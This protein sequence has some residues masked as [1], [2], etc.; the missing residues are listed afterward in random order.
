MILSKSASALAS[1]ILTSSTPG[2]ASARTFIALKPGETPAQAQQRALRIKSQLREQ[3]AIKL[4]T[5]GA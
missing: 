1:A 2:D 3:Q 5:Q 4:A